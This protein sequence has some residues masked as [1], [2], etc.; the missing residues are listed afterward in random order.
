MHKKVH[1]ISAVFVSVFSIFFGYGLVFGSTNFF[2]T[3]TIISFQLSENIFPDSL[4]LRS[5]KVV[6]ES[7]I[8]MSNFSL[9]SA[10]DMY[11]KNISKQWNLYLF[12][13]RILD[14]SCSARYL[15]LRD[16]SGEILSQVKINLKSEYRL[17]S[18][19]LDYS[20]EKLQTFRNALDNRV[21]ALWKYKEYSESL[22]MDYYAF[23]KQNR[24]LQEVVYTRNI[25]TRILD[26]RKKKY[27]I[28]VVERELP[29][30]HSKL[31][32]S[33]RP[34]RASYTD[35]IHH[36]WDIDTEFWEQVVALDDGIIIRTVPE[37]EFG[38]LNGITRWDNLT[39]QQ[40]TINLDILR[41]KQVWLK[42]MKWEVVFYSHLED[43]FDGIEEWVVVRRWQAL[44]TVGITG[45]PDEAYNDYHLHFPV[46]ENPYDEKK[47]GKYS[48]EDYMYWRWKF[49]WESFDTILK[50]QYDVFEK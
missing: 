37:F 50:Y 25:I 28:P 5:T 18:S 4:E 35:G 46:H 44:G 26:G 20:D 8:D 22:W 48:Y 34:Y 30:Q 13:I 41:W 33:G 17:F 27:A 10:C 42:T 15:F 9:D 21:L 1:I 2:Q 12:D 31:P 29:T 38:D 47:A 36:G 40:E 24:L 23:L 43:V 7:P 3:D 11:S 39:Y 6:F 16:D 32:N 45:V 49:Q 14:N 19:F